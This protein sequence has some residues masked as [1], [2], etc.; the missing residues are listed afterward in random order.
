MN[1]HDANK[2]SRFR[3]KRPWGL[4]RDFD[5]RTQLDCGLSGTRP[6]PALDIA[7]KTACLIDIC[8]TRKPFGAFVLEPA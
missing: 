7:S 1:C 2:I 5:M 8:R 4:F 3:G 6:F